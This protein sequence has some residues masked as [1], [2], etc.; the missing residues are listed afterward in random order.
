[1]AV[2]ARVT[3]VVGA[4]TVTIDCVTPMHEQAEEYRTVPEQ[5]EAY[6]GTLLGAMV[7][8]RAARMLVNL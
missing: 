5:A 3:M 4:A 8:W 1:V 2:F 6:F 7:C